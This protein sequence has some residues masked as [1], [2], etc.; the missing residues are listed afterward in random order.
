MSSYGK[1]MSSKKLREA[2]FVKEIDRLEMALQ[3]TVYEKQ[4][5]YNLEEFFPYVQQRISSPKVKEILEDL[6]RIRKA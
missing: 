2:R 1:N 3:A 4:G 6:L 5:G